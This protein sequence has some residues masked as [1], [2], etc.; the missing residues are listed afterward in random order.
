MFKISPQSILPLCSQVSLLVVSNKTSKMQINIAASE[1]LST[2]RYRPEHEPRKEESDRC[3]RS[4]FP[5]Q[6][7]WS[8]SECVVPFLPAAA[9]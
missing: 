7:G 1:S 8:R 3:S 9:G 2:K 4:E 6:G 5:P